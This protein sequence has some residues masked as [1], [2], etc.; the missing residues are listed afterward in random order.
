MDAATVGECVT[1]HNG[2]VRLNG[3]VHQARN[4]AACG[5]NLCS[6]Y[7]GVNIDT[8][9]TLQNHGNLFERSV[10]RTLTDT[11]DCHLYLTRSVQHSAQRIGCGK[12]Q[13]VVAMG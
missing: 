4:H 5:A 9:V 13:V 6:V 8:V 1:T 2:L 12:T 7:V 3:H 11:I 10:S